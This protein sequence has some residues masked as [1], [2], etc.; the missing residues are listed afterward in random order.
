MTKANL[1]E[2]RRRVG[3]VFQDPDDQLFM[4][5]VRRRRGL[6]SG[7]PRAARAT[8]STARV[9]R[10]ARRGRHGRRRTTGRPT[11]SAS[12]NAG[13][14]RWPPCWP[15]TPR[16]SCS[17]SPPPTSTRPPGASWPTSSRRSPV[18]ALIVT[19]DLPYALEL[20]PR[21]V[22]LNDGRHRGRRPH[23]GDP[24]RRRADGRQ[25]PGAAL[26][27]RPHHP[28]LITR[29]RRRA[30]GA[31]P[32]RCRRWRWRRSRGPSH[33]ALRSALSAGP[34]SPG[35]RGGRVRW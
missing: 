2:I 31:G 24:R 13:G 8:R 34:P 21:S 27:L 14:W 32:R 26:R 22:I 18:T 6:R 4:P 17:T 25:P 5:T 15:W 19:H 1:K 11:T 33:G 3:V 29:R 9:A 23:R 7:Q 12:G 30:A 10:R 28:G 16:S 20:C 35:G